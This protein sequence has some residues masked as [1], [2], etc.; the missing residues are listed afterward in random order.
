MERKIDSAYEGHSSDSNQGP[1]LFW[2]LADSPINEQEGIAKIDYRGIASWSSSA[3]AGPV[4]VYDRRI[5]QLEK[6]VKELREMLHAACNAQNVIFKEP[7]ITVR[8][9]PFEEAKEEIAL[10]FREHD[11]YDIDIDELITELAI[12][13]SIVVR[14]CDSLEAEGKIG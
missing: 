12:D 9:I 10:Y 14:A 5:S 7:I 8:D 1:Y 6:E 11:G 3:Y 2:H 13:P 4:L